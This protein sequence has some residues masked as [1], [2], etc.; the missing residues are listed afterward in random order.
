MRLHFLGTASGLPT[1]VRMGQTTILEIDGS[2]HILDAGDGASSLLARSGLS[3]LDV[4]SIVIS[5]MHGDHH[6]GLLQ[7]VKTMMHLKKRDPLLVYLPGEGI[8]PLQTLLES[9]YLV[10]EWL[11][12]EIVWIPVDP[13]NPQSLGP[14]V[15]VQ[16]FANEHLAKTRERAQA[17]SRI[18]AGWRYQSYSFVVEAKGVRIAYSGNLQA[19][20][21]EMHP[22]AAGVDVLISELAHLAPLDSLEALEMLRPRHAIFAHFHRMW[23]DPQNWDRGGLTRLAQGLPGVSVWIT[24]DGDVFEI[25]DEGRLSRLG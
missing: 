2:L 10:P 20:L 22:Y 4:R 21:K 1:P 14:G 3:H 15:E 17:L 5:H 9:S 12:F 25:D 6:C 16:A 13:Q 24:K 11:G 18:P 23:D 8:S 7:L 19:S